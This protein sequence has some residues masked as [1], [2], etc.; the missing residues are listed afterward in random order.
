MYEQIVSCITSR[1]YKDPPLVLG[2]EYNIDNNFK[3][4]YGE[5]GNGIRI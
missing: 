1:I 4:A 3:K 5:K 2:R